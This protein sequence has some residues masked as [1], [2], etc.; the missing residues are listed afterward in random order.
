MTLLSWEEIYKKIETGKAKWEDFSFE[1]RTPKEWLRPYLWQIDEMFHKRWSYWFKVLQTNKIKKI[2]KIYFLEQPN[3]ETINM[4]KNCVSKA[5]SFNNFIEW[6]AWGVGELEEKPK[7]L[8]EVNESLYKQFNAGLMI[9]YPY[10]YFGDIYA[11]TVPTK[12]LNSGA[13]FPTPHSICKLLVN[14]Q[15]LGS[16]KK[17]LRTASI[18]DPC[19][20]TGRILLEASNYSVNLYGQDI[21]N[22]CVL[23][24]KINGWLY[25]PWIVKPLGLLKKENVISI[26][27]TKP[28]NRKIT[29]TKYYSMRRTK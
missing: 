2:P 16:D 19:L 15:I 13:F 4:L 23:C 26:I 17:K 3:K 22:D 18:Y 28:V 27:R 10:D 29:R 21:N 5:G 1:E 9:K 8:P 25:A 11:E 6:L 20:G 7:L 24:S 12:F 14:T